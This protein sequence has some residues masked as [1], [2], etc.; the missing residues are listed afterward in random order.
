MP[1][2]KQTK[3]CSDCPFRKKAMKGWLGPWQPE[4]I[5]QMIHGEN[6]YICHSD[7]NKRS[8]VGQSESQI[9][10]QG[11]HC[12]GFLRY[13]TKVCKTS[14]DED[15]RAHQYKLKEIDDQE[16]IDAFQFV[17]HHTEK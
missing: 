17:A 13:R 14:R 1:Q 16:V 6:K 8:S 15:Q 10:E 4:E 3:M 7:I 5:Q 12:V 11:Q 9:D 2:Y